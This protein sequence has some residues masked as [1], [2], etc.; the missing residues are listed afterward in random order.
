VINSSASREQHKFYPGLERAKI[1][2]KFFEVTT[3]PA[4]VLPSQF[5]R[6]VNEDSYKV[7]QAIANQVSNE[8]NIMQQ[9][10]GNSINHMKSPQSAYHAS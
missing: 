3:M 1:L 9:E 8:Y 5:N 4:P 2:N 7:T 6:R 10:T